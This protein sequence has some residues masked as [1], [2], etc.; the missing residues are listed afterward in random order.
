MG[1]DAGLKGAVWRHVDSI[2][3][4]KGMPHAKVSGKDRS[5]GHRGSE[6]RP[7]RLGQ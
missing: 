6:Q 2:F 4:K 1:K 5:Y 7:Q 3:H